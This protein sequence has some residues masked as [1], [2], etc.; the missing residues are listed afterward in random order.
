[1]LDAA[2]DLPNDVAELQAMI[3]LQ[4]QKLTIFETELKERDYR[5]EKLKHE[6]AGLRRYRFGSRSEALDQLELTLEE[7]EIAR[8]AETPSGDENTDQTAD[9]KPNRCSM[10]WRAGSMPSFRRSPA[11]RSWPRQ[12]DTP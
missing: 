3:A 10:I 7:E 1:M 12:S 8:A 9:D 2:S 4:S 11:S 5:I 6:L